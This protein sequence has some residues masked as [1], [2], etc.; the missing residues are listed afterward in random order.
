MESG[1]TTLVAG[2][3]LAGLRYLTDEAVAIR[4]ADGG[5]TPFPKALSVDHG[6][7]PSCRRCVRSCRPRQST[8]EGRSGRCRPTTSG[9]MPSPPVPCRQPSCCL[10]TSGGA[11]EPSS[12]SR[13]GTALVELLRRPSRSTVRAAARHAGA[14]RRDRRRAR[15]TGWSWAGSTM[16]WSVLL[17]LAGDD[18]GGGRRRDALLLR[19]DRLR[20]GRDAARR[21]RR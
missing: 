8:C 4:P 6:S 10:G 16:R 18:E 1:K 15:A 17:A 3:V 5:I 20:A 19:S 21:T 7:W 9:R 2:L 14:R 13:P 12:R 11:D